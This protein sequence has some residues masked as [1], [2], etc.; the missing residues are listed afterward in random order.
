[1][2]YLVLGTILDDAAFSYDLAAN[3]ASTKWLS[4]FAKGLLKNN[5]EV[6][7]CGHCYARAW[8]KGAL[9]PG[10]KE[11]L[12]HEF[13]NHLVSF[14]NFPGIRF[15]SMANSYYNAANSIAQKKNADCLVTYNPYPWNVYAAR[16]IRKKYNI[17]WICLN[18]DFDNVGEGWKSFSKIAGDADGHLFLSHWGFNYAPYQNKIHLDAGIESIPDVTDIS[19]DDFLNLVYVGKLSNSGGLDTLLK[20]P[21]LINNRKVR[22]Y[23]GGKA[24]PADHGKLKALSR[25]DS[26]VNYL[27]FVEDHDLSDLFKK[28]DIFLNPRDPLDVVNDMVF[29]SK[30]MHYLVYQKTIIS[31]WTPG[32]APCYKDLLLFSENPSA[33]SFAMALNTALLETKS[34]RK[35][36]GER[37]RIFLE[38]S[39]R[40]DLQAKRFTLFAEN[41]ISEFQKD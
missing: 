26:R 1:M 20:I 40:W 4:G 32:L 13:N 15:S 19:D 11:Y 37:I 22:F 25:K 3:P 28:A 24:S 41:V 14:I 30:I 5:H 36:R 31:T 10:K 34:A 17:P 12:N 7:L 23:Y 6:S 33:A 18:L 16:R 9:F 2:N 27:G 35:N 38:E 8:P 21:S 39:R 29:P